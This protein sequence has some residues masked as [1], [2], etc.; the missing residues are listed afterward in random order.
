MQLW[1]ANNMLAGVGCSRLALPAGGRIILSRTGGLQ[2]PINAQ[3]EA[4]TVS[5][6]DWHDTFRG[7]N[8]HRTASA[9]TIALYMM[10]FSIDQS[11]E[12]ALSSLSV[13]LLLG[14]EVAGASG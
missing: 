3:L 5:S 11:V 2:T 7:P 4:G 8:T 1:R 13:S 12:H 9:T 6:Y 14:A 10:N